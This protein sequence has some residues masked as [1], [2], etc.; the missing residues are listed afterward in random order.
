MIRILYVIFLAVIVGSFAADE[1]QSK[2]DTNVPDDISGEERKA[3]VIEDFETGTVGGDT[4]WQIQSEPKQFV[5]AETEK[6]LKMKNPV[7]V[8]EM[9]LI[10]GFPNDMS[11]EEWSLT[12]LG[13]KKEKCLGVKFQFRYPGASNSIHILPPKELD[14]KR[15]NP[16]YRYNPSTRKDEQERGLQ[17]PG[18]ARG[19][20]MWIHARGKPYTLEVWVKDY[21]GD[22]HVF[23]FGSVNFVGWRP[24]KIYIPTNVPMETSSYP[25]IRVA[26]ITRFVLRAIPGANAEDLTEPTFFFF[27]QIKVL[28][29]TFEVNFDG[30]ELDKAFSGESRNK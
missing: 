23:K 19:I 11:V 17:L 14:W 9:K 6:K 27:D 5:N 26:K 28:T 22:T 13:K 1:A 21:R 10:N 24:L 3:V 18:K 4:G 30:Q 8:L 25:Q 15:K 16:V 20:S 2:I 29:D 7:P 12:D